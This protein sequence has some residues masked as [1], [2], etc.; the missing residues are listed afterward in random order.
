MNTYLVRVG[1][2]PVGTQ[3]TLGTVTATE[4]DGV[5]HYLVTF[6]TGETKRL[7]FAQALSVI[8]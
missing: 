7:R 1:G 3:T 8:A 2:C 6:S 5:E 4:R